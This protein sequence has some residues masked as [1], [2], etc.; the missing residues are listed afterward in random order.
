MTFILHCVNVVYHVICRCLPSLHSWHKSC[1]IIVYD[2]FNVLLNLFAN[3]LLRALNRGYK[4]SEEIAI[5]GWLS[6]VM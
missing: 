6:G 3:V 1:L 5:R 4:S 2:P